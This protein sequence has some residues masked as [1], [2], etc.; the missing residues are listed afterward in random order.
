MTINW[1]FGCPESCQRLILKS[2]YACRIHPKVWNIYMKHSEKGMVNGRIYFGFPKTKYAKLKSFIY[3][4]WI[5]LVDYISESH[6]HQIFDFSRLNC[7]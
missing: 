4:F 6:G 7:L 3:L 5:K 1:W 2:P